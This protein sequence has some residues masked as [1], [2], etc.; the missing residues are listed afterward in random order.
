MKLVNKPEI[1]NFISK[2]I[3]VKDLDALLS[4]D[5][6]IDS[7][8]VVQ[9]LVCLNDKYELNMSFE[10]LHNKSINDITEN[11]MSIKNCDN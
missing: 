5:N 11:I 3:K 7:L 4:S 1:A 9:L 10:D 8:V 6:D 2:N